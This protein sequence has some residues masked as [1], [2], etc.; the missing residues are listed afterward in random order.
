[1][2][3]YHYEF[4]TIDELEQKTYQDEIDVNPVHQRPQRGAA[5]GSIEKSIGIIKSLLVKK[6]SPGLITL[7][8]ISSAEYGD[9]KY[10][11]LDGGHR[12]RAII[13][14]LNKKF[15]VDDKLFTELSPNEQKAFRD[16]KLPFCIYNDL[17]GPEKAGI[18]R[19]V[20]TTTSVNEQEKRNSTGN[21][22]IATII[23]NTVRP[24]NV[25][26]HKLFDR[27]IIKKTGRITQE[28]KYL[29]FT[30]DAL[31]Q[32]EWLARL[33]FYAKVGKIVSCDQSDLDKLYNDNPTQN[34]VDVLTSKVQK[35]LNFVHLMTVQ[36]L[37]HAGV[38]GEKKMRMDIKEANMFVRLWFDLNAKYN[39]DLRGVDFKTIKNSTV[40]D[41]Y[42]A[43]RGV[44]T[45]IISHYKDKFIY[46]NFDSRNYN[47]DQTIGVK[48]E[49]NLTEYRYDNIHATMLFPVEVVL[50]VINPTDYLKLRDSTR[51]VSP[52]QKED[53]LFKNNWKC[54]RTGIDL[55]WSEAEGDHEIPTAAGIEAGGV[56]A[57]HNLQVV[58]KT[59]NR[60]K[61][62]KMPDQYN[63]VKT[64]P[65]SNPPSDGL[66][67]I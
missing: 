7:N 30:N 51:L 44:M 35:V 31:K 4:W 58:S 45:D 10:E 6:Q 42:D 19:D 49:N 2:P 24:D 48:F 17:T 46:G 50:S 27:N 11:S 34:E 41:F 36:R 18:F 25:E 61:S 8:Y 33:Y 65:L 15:K 5:S 14:Y 39:L 54:E 64:P 16:I 63:S 57:P 1:M 40:T 22:P 28:W 23:R 29:S 67:K 60:V 32:E 38:G 13:D 21:L 26:T 66:D 3:N 56:T 53:M 59:Y 9:Y 43:V 55:K 62:D 37:S 20:N 47:G 12:K 52:I